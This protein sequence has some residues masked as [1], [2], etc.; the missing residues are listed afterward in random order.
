MNIRNSVFQ[1]GLI[2]GTILDLSQFRLKK[3]TVPTNTKSTW[4][5]LMEIKLKFGEEITYLVKNLLFN[6]FCL[7]VNTLFCSLIRTMLYN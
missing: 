7:L 2:K 4:N 3:N 6:G 1:L 5:Y